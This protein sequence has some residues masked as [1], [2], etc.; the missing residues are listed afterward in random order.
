MFQMF[1]NDVQKEYLQDHFLYKSEIDLVRP[2]MKSKRFRITFKKWLE[3]LK[4]SRDMQITDVNSQNSMILQLKK[5]KN[6]LKKYNLCNRYLID[7]NVQS[8]NFEKTASKIY[9]ERAN[10]L[11]KTENYYEALQS[12]LMMTDTSEVKVVYRLALCA[13]KSNEKKLFEKN[14]SFLKELYKN[15]ESRS[16][17]DV[18]ELKKYQNEYEKLLKKDVVASGNS[19]NDRD[20]FLHKFKEISIKITPKEGRH[21]ILNEHVEDNTKLFKENAFA[22]VPLLP[23][24]RNYSNCQGCATSNI[25]PVFC[26]ICKGGFCSIIC[27][28]SHTYECRG[29]ELGIWPEVGIAYL[30]F[31]IFINGFHQFR[32]MLEES[33]DGKTLDE[34]LK[35]AVEVKFSP[36]KEQYRLLLSLETHF[37]Q[38]MHGDLVTFALTSCA[39]ILYLQMETTFFKDQ[40]ILLE[41][42]KWEVLASS[43]LL[44]HIG[45]SICNAHTMSDLKI[46]F[47]GELFPPFNK[48]SNEIL[49][50]ETPII[51][52]V[53]T[54]AGIFPF[55]SLLNH[56]CKSNIRNCFNGSHLTIY[57]KGIIKNDDE[58]LNNYGINYLR[59]CKTDRQI[60][61]REQYHFNC[62]CEECSKPHDNYLILQKLRCVVCQNLLEA[63]FDMETM[64]V[65]SKKK[66]I[67]NHCGTYFNVD[68]F[69]QMIRK[70]SE[71]LQEI[72]SQN[73]LDNTIKILEYC[74][75]RLN[76]YHEVI[77]FFSKSLISSLDYSKIEEN[78][79]LAKVAENMLKI[80]Q[81][82]YGKYSIEFLLDNL[83]VMKFLSKNK[84]DIM[85][86]ASNVL[87]DQ[88]FNIFKNVYKVVSIC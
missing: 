79:E 1:L 2:I 14:L 67:C 81:Y 3:H 61:L 40:K 9:Y 11:I 20:K 42:E 75:E 80:C 34:I 73:M 6:I 25:V 86:L 37:D 88:S 52:N 63:T 15:M 30:A 45:Q 35:S 36:E 54:F 4:K 74:M 82:L 87:S 50:F 19:L 68:E 77:Y 21:I 8:D 28:K 58:I 62:K 17:K 23:S 46:E 22:F 31:K 29:S 72:Y 18:E 56:S 65:N 57:S 51:Q 16:E 39:L 33:F 48:V 26:K 64:E 27:M 41:D 32:I 83:S 38:M 76:P 49:R 53:E 59:S 13:L 10:I 5:C 71:N 85:E 7:L 70:L 78:V 12:L 55:I 60:A 84:S 69:E 47:G 43:L 24:S 66:H 44:R